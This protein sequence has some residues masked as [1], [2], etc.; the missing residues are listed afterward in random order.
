MT[1][2][3]HNG[4]AHDLAEHLRQNTSR[5]VWEDMQLG[6]AGSP[7]PDVYAV[8][9]SFSKFCP[10]AYECK[11][12]VSDF[13]ADVTKGKY[14]SYM[15][16]ASGIVFAVPEGLIKKSDLPAGCGLMVRGENGWRTVKGPTLNAV[17][18]LPRDAWIKLLI[19]G[20]QRE[21]KRTEL[22]VRYGSIWVTER[23]LAKRH[24]EEVAHLVRE[25]LLSSERLRDATAKRE[26]AR[27][28]IF[29][30]TEEEKK[31]RW[32]ALERSTGRLNDAQMELAS[33]LGLPENATISQLTRA[34]YEA[35]NRLASDREIQRFRN[36]FRYLERTIADGNEPLPGENSA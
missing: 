25:A 23:E 18:N 4:L 17:D 20:I 15:P 11:I 32:E 7:R 16:F 36:L 26:A 8:P 12:S 1:K 35:R 2:W 13:R 14:T 30:E 19:D 6:P 10:I 22:K 31:R 33:A 3:T 27:E 9:F 5:F 24:G 21:S 29:R 28:E 34:I